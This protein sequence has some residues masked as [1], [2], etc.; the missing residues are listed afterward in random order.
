MKVW[1]KYS[2]PKNYNFVNPLLTVCAISHSSQTCDATNQEKVLGGRAD[3]LL[4]HLQPDLAPVQRHV[5]LGRNGQYLFHRFAASMAIQH[6][7]VV[8]FSI[9]SSVT[10]T[11]F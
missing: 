11:I 10:S 4:L 3:P 8:S 9:S 5:C 7:S 2:F 6:I 1:N